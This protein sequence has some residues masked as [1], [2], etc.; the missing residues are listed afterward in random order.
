MEQNKYEVLIVGGGLAGLSLAIMCAQSGLKVLLI[1][2]GS[3]PRHKV[4]G[5]YI[6][7]ESYDV[8]KK[9]GIPLKTLQVPFINKFV[10]TSPHS[11]EAT[12]RMNTGGFGISRYY[13]DEKLAQLAVDAGVKLL[14]QTKVQHMVKVHNGY[15]VTTQK[16]LV[17]ESP[18]L[19]GSYGRISGLH[20]PSKVPQKE[21]VG[22]KYHVDAGP[23]DDTI[24]IHH[25]RG[26][27]CGVSKVENGHYNLCYLARSVDLK[28]SKG[29][30]DLLEQRVLM[31]NPCLA[32]RLKTNR[33][34]EP[35]LTSGLFFGVHTTPGLSYPQIGDAA[36][37][38]PPL[39]GN[40]MSLAFRS[41]VFMH[42]EILSY[43]SH[44]NPHQLLKANQ[45]YVSTYLKHRINKGI[46][47]QQLLFSAHPIV[48]QGLWGC[49]RLFP[50]LLHI[51]TKQAVGKKIT[52]YQR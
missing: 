14:T 19:V 24:E 23:E 4:C 15:Q 44:R 27:Y 28:E 9:L 46:M 35:V 17:F 32:E 6:S 21:F 2:K 49:F 10:L 45:S 11:A 12:T 39:T 38:I 1:E 47:L 48:Q 5:E 42:Q 52:A 33:L 41:A 16:G 31:K 18:L 34:F 22:V 36:G 26:G 51:M 50:G 25:F 8:V 3:Y 30:I 13:L 7:M 29:N 20:H 37:F 40:G 43:Q